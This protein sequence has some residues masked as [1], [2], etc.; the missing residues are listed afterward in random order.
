MFRKSSYFWQR[1]HP[2]AGGGFTLVELLVVIAI[3]GI[4]VALLLPAVQA[5]REAARRMQCVNNLKQ[6]GV[7][8]QLYHDAHKQLP[9]GSRTAPRQTWTMYLWPFIEQVALDSQNEITEPFYLPP[10]TIGGTLDGLTGQYVDMYNCPSDFGADQTLGNYQRRRGNYVVNWGNSRYGAVIDQE[11]LAPFSHIRGRRNDPRVTTFAHITDGTSNT[12]VM[13]EVL[14][15]WSNEDNDW[16]GDVHNDDG[17]FR[18]HTL[19]TPN[20]SAPDIIQGGWFQRT[21]DPMMPATAGSARNQVAAARSRHSGGVNAVKCD[22]SVQFFSDDISLNVW[23]AF[24]TI[25]GEETIDE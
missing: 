10:G 2:Y 9:L 17:V 18:F 5:A 20:T 21:D 1:R 16:R 8:M 6:W 19:L 3:I 13:S 12:L 22:G 14:K 15:A 24:G 11:A 7:A 23:K 25:N 4:L